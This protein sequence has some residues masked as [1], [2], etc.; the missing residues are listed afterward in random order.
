MARARSARIDGRHA[1]GRFIRQI[2]REILR[3]GENAP[4]LEALVE[5]GAIGRGDRMEGFERF[6][7]VGGLMHVRLEIAE[8]RAFDRR[9]RIGAIQPPCQLFH[10]FLFER[11][12][13]GRSRPAQ[14]ERRAL[15]RPHH[16]QAF[17]A[18]ALR[19]VEHGELVGFGRKFAG[20]A[21]LIEPSG[22]ELQLGRCGIVF[23]QNHRNGVSFDFF[24]R[25]V[26]EPGFH[27]HHSV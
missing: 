27:V 7:L 4:A 1:I 17:R 9:L 19:L 10:A 25:L 12:N 23:E 26:K 14:I 8:N 16:D 11:A 5:L 15:S 20:A 24:E 3:V 22:R 21:H 13:H 2:A 18:N 6:A